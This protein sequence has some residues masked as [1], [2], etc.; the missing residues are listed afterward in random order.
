MSQVPVIT[1]DGPSGVGK[2][3]ISQ[4]L[5][6][7]L[8]WHMLD[9]G[10]LYRAVGWAASQRGLTEASEEALAKLA[11]DL[12]VEFVPQPGALTEVKIDGEAVGDS[13]RTEEAA[14][15]ASKVAALPKV[16][17]ALMA[18]QLAFRQMPG[19]VADGRDMGSQVF[20]DAELK[21]FLTASPET[22]AQR[23]HKQLKEKDFSVN[24]A[25][26]VEEIRARDERDANRPV[27]P[28]RPAEDAHEIDTGPLTIDAVMVEIRRL[29]QETGYRR[30]G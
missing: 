20:P 14:A 13:L 5:A 30:P 24:L 15:A 17:E 3:T 12:D 9:S 19:L 11:S 26:L 6:Q 1:V 16:R 4:L 18:K 7:E 8:G 2:G 23:R 22:R 21:I 29:L 25:R 10:A 28:M 27:S